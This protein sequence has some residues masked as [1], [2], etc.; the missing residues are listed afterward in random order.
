MVFRVQVGNHKL[1]AVLQQ[2]PAPPAPAVRIVVRH[3]VVAG[4][5]VAVQREKAVMVF[6]LTEDGLIRDVDQNEL[7]RAGIYPDTWERAGELA[8]VAHYLPEVQSFFAAAAED[9]DAVICWL[10]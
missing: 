7:R 4:D 1:A 6:A 5:T 8:W 2:M 9:G 10:D 3:A